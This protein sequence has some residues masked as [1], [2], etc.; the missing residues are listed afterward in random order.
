MKM[1]IRGIFWIGVFALLLA[2]PAH[3]IAGDQMLFEHKWIGPYDSYFGGFE[4]PTGQHT[5]IYKMRD[6][7]EGVVCYIYADELERDD[8]RGHEKYEYQD[9]N[10]GSISCVKTRKS[11]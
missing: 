9:N 6:V 2:V 8:S 11:K 7:K 1:T 5:V 3:A 4:A 10:A